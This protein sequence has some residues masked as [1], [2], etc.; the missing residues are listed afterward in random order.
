MLELGSPKI[1]KVALCLDISRRLLSL[2]AS[3]GRGCPGAIFRQK[4]RVVLSDT[5]IVD[6]LT[7]CA[8]RLSLREALETGLKTGLS[9]SFA[10]EQC[11]MLFCSCL[12]LELQLNPVETARQTLDLQDQW[13][14]QVTALLRHFYPSYCQ[15]LRPCRASPQ[16][17]VS[18]CHSRPVGCF[19][20]TD[21]CQLPRELP[22]CST[23]SRSPFTRLV[24]SCR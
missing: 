5:K 11:H 2:K 16:P 4:K 8:N 3:R 7:S 15:R 21:T 12:L 9:A 17:T 18:D 13:L 1:L 24:P 19:V 23:W 20:A 22:I 10:N 14:L 6:P